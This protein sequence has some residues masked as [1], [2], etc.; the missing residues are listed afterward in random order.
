MGGSDQLSSVYFGAFVCDPAGLVKSPKTPET[1]KYEKIT[2]KYKTP[3]P[4]WVPKNTRK[5]PKKYKSGPKMTIFVFFR[6]FFRIFGAPPGVGGFVFF[7]N[8]FVFWGFRGFWAL[9]QARGIA[10]LCFLKVSFECHAGGNLQ[11]YDFFGGARISRMSN[12]YFLPKV[13]WDH[14]MQE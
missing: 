8:F 3:H 6:Y 2:K 12:A 1:P 11:I 5:I 4:G 14:R 13:F 9:Y 10:S 7:R